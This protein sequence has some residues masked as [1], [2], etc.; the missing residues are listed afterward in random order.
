MEKEQD[1]GV[2]TMEVDKLGD[3]YPMKKKRVIL[4]RTNRLDQEI[5]LPK[6]IE[7]LKRG[8]YAI[9]L[10]CWDRDC[11]SSNS[12][13]SGEHEEIKLRLKAPIGV[14][15]LPFLPIWWSF[16]FVHLMMSKWDVAHAVNFDSIIPAT[17]AGKL[18][19][20]PVVYEILDI[21]E[22]EIV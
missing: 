8:G 12:E 17:I 7:V 16:V 6:E 10:L 3:N 14:K 20:N 13:K 21:Y 1:V 5:R 9:T 2:Y 22:G 15:I 11:K 18:K 4:I 19:R